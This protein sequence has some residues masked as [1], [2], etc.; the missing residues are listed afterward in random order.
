LLLVDLD[1][2][3]ID[4]AS[5]FDRWAREVASVREVASAG[6]GGGADAEWLVTG[7]GSS[8]GSGSRR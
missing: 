2:T 8:R 4:R 3:L 7:T 1:N 5:A 6:G